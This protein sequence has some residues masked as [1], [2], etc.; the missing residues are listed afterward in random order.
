MKV[1]RLAVVSV[2]VALLWLALAGAEL[3]GAAGQTAARPGQ[4]PQPPSFATRT[5]LVPVVVRAIDAK[6]G[7]PVTDLKQ[8]EFTVLEDGKPQVIKHF[9]RHL[10]TPEPAAAA[11]RPQVRE[12]ALDLLPQNGRIILIVFGRGRLQEPSKALD[13]LPHF[14]REQ[15]LPQD[16]VA[17]FAYDRASDFTTDHEQIAQFIE[18]FK[19]A[20]YE[21]DMEVRLAI[22]SSLAAIYGSRSLPK[23]VRQK[24]D[25]MFLGAGLLGSRELGKGETAATKRADQEAARQVAQAQRADVHDAAVRMDQWAASNLGTTYASASATLQSWSTMDEVEA[26]TFATLGLDN[27]MEITARSLQDLGN[28]YAAIEYMRHLEGDKHLIFVTEKGLNL[29]SLDDDMDLARAA[30]DARVA[31]DTFQ[32]GGLEA[33]QG[34]VWTDQSQQTFAFKGLRMLAEQT[35]GVSSISEDGMVAVTRINEVSRSE[36]ILGYYPGPSSL[37]GDYRRIEVRASRPFVKLLYRRGY[38]GRTEVGSYNRRDAVTR[39]RLEAAATFRR[40]VDDIK[41]R[42][43]AS[44]DKDQSGANVVSVRALIDVSRLYLSL[45]DGHR[46]G[47]V[48]ILTVCFDNKNQVV[49]QMYQRAGIDLTPEMFDRVSRNGLPY[50]VR[51]EAS[52]ATR[53]IRVVVYDY[54]ADLAGSADRSIF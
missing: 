20:H 30:N 13:A 40:T 12:A 17:V 22:E 36:Y 42:L 38:Y 31:I 24:I 18:R 46:T 1:P 11:A 4:P 2:V 49:G 6:T 37:T 21:I 50:N 5:V 26:P 7:K 54:R 52:P 39:E 3:I 10:Y 48:D 29:P 9:E 19:K 43:D 53:R 14:V 47:A 15:L 44:Q 8:E 51:F 33:Q 23:S 16:Q 25:M 35:G 32:V 34:G 27:F 41:V 28:C 45:V